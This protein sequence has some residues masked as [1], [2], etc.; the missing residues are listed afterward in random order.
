MNKYESTLKEV[1]RGS[2]H[3]LEANGGLTEIPETSLRLVCPYFGPFT[4]FCAAEML[5]DDSLRSSS[6]HQGITNR[7]PAN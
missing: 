3:G 1:G 2:T 4:H 5:G 6:L 7:V